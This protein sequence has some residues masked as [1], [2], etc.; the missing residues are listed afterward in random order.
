[1]RSTKT[2]AKV[3]LVFAYALFVLYVGALIISRR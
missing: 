2:G 1:M 3:F